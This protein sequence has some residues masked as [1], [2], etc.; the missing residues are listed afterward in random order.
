MSGA[1][2]I[3]TIAES[4]LPG[5]DATGFL[6]ILGPAGLSREVV[7][8][9]SAETLKVVQRRDVQDWL[10]LQGGEAAPGTAEQFAARIAKEREK[11]AKVIRDV[12]MRLD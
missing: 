7:A 9:L 3:P 4:G 11:L 8:K 5:F 6:G 10:S 1:P 12:G 2:D